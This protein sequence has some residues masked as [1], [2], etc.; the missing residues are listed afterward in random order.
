[1]GVVMNIVKLSGLTLLTAIAATGSAFTEGHFEACTSD[2]WVLKSD[3]EFAKN[4]AD[5]AFNGDLADRQRLAWMFFARA[6]LQIEGGTR[7]DKDTG[8]APL[9]MAWPTDPE[10]FPKKPGVTPSFEFEEKAVDEVIKPSVP[11]TEL[12]G[13]ISD[14]T[15]QGAPNSGEEE[16]TRN[17]ISYEYIVENTLYTTPGVQAFTQN[18]NPVEMPVGSIETK[19]KWIKLNTL[20][21]APAGAFVFEFFNPNAKK[22]ENQQGY[23]YWGGMHIMAKMQPSPS[24]VFTDNSGSWFWTTFEFKGNPGVKHVVDSFIT[25][26]SPLTA[27]EI[28]AIMDTAGLLGFGYEAYAPNGTQISFVDAEEQAVILGHTQMEDFAGLPVGPKG[29]PVPPPDWTGFT[30]SCHTCHATAAYQPTTTG[31]NGSYFPFTVPIGALPTNSSG[32][33]DYT[34]TQG[35]KTYNL[36]DGF[37]SLDFM[38]PI[39]FNARAED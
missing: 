8:T 33:V 29:N 24:D 28:E 21:D 6:N 36:G 16:V 11:K 1:M 2:G 31:D 13:I 38:W 4:C 25:Q 12:A 5:M 9:W 23:Y 34:A 7:V 14:T 19:A 26:K 20:A 22:E 10:T 18:G 30:A 27:R 37:V 32:Q 39:T 15:Q 3:A 35:D 17:Q